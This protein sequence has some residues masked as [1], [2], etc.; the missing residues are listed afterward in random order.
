MEPLGINFGLLLIQL[1][2]VGVTV[3]LPVISVIDLARKKLTGVPL[4]LWVLIICA[5]PVL[6]SVAYWIVRPTAEGNA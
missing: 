1:V 5:I 6:G 4:A 2:I 3:G